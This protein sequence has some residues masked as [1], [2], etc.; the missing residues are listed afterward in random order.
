MNYLTE[1]EQYKEH[2]SLE[3]IGRIEDIGLSTIRLKYW[4]LRH[5]AFLKEYEIPDKD[6]ERV[7][8]RLVYEEKCEIERYS[9]KT[10]NWSVFVM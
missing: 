6:L 1:E 2:I 10:L 3:E 5:E 8:N 4:K 9:G 7:H